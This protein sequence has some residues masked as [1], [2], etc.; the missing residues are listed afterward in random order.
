MTRVVAA[1]EHVSYKQANHDDD[2][3]SREADEAETAAAA[4]A[5]AA[6]VV[7]AAR[8]LSPQTNARRM[9]KRHRGKRR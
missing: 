7:V 4:A 5:A 8:A 1:T 6:A 2:D 3:A 9:A